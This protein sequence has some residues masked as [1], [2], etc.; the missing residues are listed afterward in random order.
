MSSTP[1]AVTNQL[2]FSGINEAG[3]YLIPPMDP[4]EFTQ[5]ALGIPRDQ[6]HVDDLQARADANQSN[7]GVIRGI[8]AKNLAEA[9]WGLVFSGIPDPAIY[10]AL[11]PL[12]TLRKS[13]AGDRYKE[14][15]ADK[16]FIAGPSA[17]TDFLKRNGA[18]Y[19]GPVDPARVPYY[20][21]L[22]GG[23]SK[24]PFEFQYQIDVQ[25][26][27]GRLDFDTPEEFARYAQTVVDAEQGR[28]KL[29]KRAAFFGPSNPGDAA[30]TLSSKYLIGPLAQYCNKGGWEIDFSQPESS[31]R[32]KLEQLLGAAAAPAFLM[33]AGHGMGY[34]ATDQR[35]RDF[36][37]SLLCQDWP[38]PSYRGPVRD[39][40]F[41]GEDLSSDASVAGMI[42]MFFACYGAGTPLKNDF[43]LMEGIAQANQ[44]APDPFVSRLPQ[45]M[46]GH[47]KGGALA[48]I[49]HID[50]VWGLSFL[51]DNTTPSLNTFQSALDSI[52]SG[53]PLGMASEYFNSRYADIST[54]LTQ[55]L[56]DAQDNKN[57]MPT[58]PTA[59][60]NLW[61]SN[62]D[63]RNFVIL[64]DPAVRLPLS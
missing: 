36:A 19:Y 15:T 3:E 44:I 9:G 26:A 35:Q 37:G 39:F 6:G 55:V 17:K 40:Y 25:Y 16:G 53:E 49:G 20:L 43:H 38:G 46:M 23:P 58:D 41:S 59:F 64:G 34:P 11:Q 29:P 24:I 8:D 4:V 5:R 45:R 52:L 48:V 7:L 2:F 27:V 33:T 42:T 57:G 22:I 54:D 32:A 28:L 13:Q 50:Q 51:D 47:P 31:N 60:A 21:L 10:S 14:Y 12:L 56:Q 30:T 61:S 63:A 18:G 62:N 1:I